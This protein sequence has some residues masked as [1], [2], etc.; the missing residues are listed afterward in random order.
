MEVLCAATEKLDSNVAALI[1]PYVFGD[2]C[3]NALDLVMELMEQGRCG[4]NAPGESFH[5]REREPLTGEGS[6]TGYG[7]AEGFLPDT[8]R[9][10][11]EEQRR[12]ES[13]AESWRQAREETHGMIIQEELL[14]HK[15]VV[16]G[17]TCL[18]L[19]VAK[20][21][22]AEVRGLALNSPCAGRFS[23]KKTKGRIKTTFSGRG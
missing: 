4:S 1:T 12:D 23:Q 22:L 10:F 14:N 19:E 3:A 16:V 8:E 6:D 21:R 15:D 9:S 2:L 11:A 13:L 20:S 7:K 18:Q 5:S 17:K